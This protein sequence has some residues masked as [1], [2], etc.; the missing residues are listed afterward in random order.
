MRYQLFSVNNTGSMKTQGVSVFFLNLHGSTESHIHIPT[1]RGL[2]Q[3]QINEKALG[4]PL[5]VSNFK[6]TGTCRQSAR[7][8][9]ESGQYS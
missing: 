3:T 8:K 5:N 7:E 2:A 4:F 6:N 9:T 1:R